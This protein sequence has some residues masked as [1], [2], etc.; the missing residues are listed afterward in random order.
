MCLICMK[1]K[2][3]RQGSSTMMISLPSKWIKANK[4]DKGSEVDLEEENNRLVIGTETKG[5]LETSINLP[6]LAESLIRVLIVN[7]Y[8]EGYD[9]IIVH[10]SD[11]KQFKILQEIIKTKLIGFDI[12]KKEKSSCTVENVTEP[13][14]NQF[15]NIL[16]KLFDNILELIEITKQKLESKKPEENFEET[17]DRI[18]K[19]DNFCRRVINKQN[20]NKKSEF[21]IF[22]TQI[23]HA[24]R[25]VYH[26]NKMS[27]GKHEKIAGL[28]NE[29]KELFNLITKSYKEKNPE[30]L[31]KIHELEKEILYKK[32][33]LA[34][35]KSKGKESIIIYH[36]L[37]SIRNLYLSSS[38][39][40]ILIMS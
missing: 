17:E 12:I 27:T 7:S 26:L 40:S 25:E 30:I 11:E 1:R 8:R 9:K 6:S 3:V 21:L 29:T 37:S 14:I 2:L 19:Y 15:D 23:N 28:L 33:Y 4:L 24:Q 38:P 20:S 13:S 39:L 16:G 5:K 32:G 34:L 36:I 22:L 35:E 18:Q 31:A 10:L